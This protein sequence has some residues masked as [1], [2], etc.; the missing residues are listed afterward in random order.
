MSKRTSHAGAQ[1]AALIREQ[2]HKFSEVIESAINSV[3]LDCSDL[4][5]HFVSLER[6]VAVLEKIV[7]EQ[8]KEIERLSRLQQPDSSIG[9]IG[10][11]ADD[12]PN[13]TE[14]NKSGKIEKL[15]Y[16]TRRASAPSLARPPIPPVPST[17]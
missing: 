16:P 17:K 14:G 12:T 4:A 9:D 8:K 1:R 13:T 10:G 5:D 2:T 6:R 3:S 15:G 7:V 11:D